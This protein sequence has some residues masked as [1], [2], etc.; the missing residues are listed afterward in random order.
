MLRFK[1]AGSTT[2]NIGTHGDLRRLIAD[3]VERNEAKQPRYGTGRYHHPIAIAAIEGALFNALVVGVDQD[4]NRVVQ[5][6]AAVRLRTLA[7]SA[8]ELADR[9]ES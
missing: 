7:A 1:P 4:V 2:I 6:V 9:L 3:A 5:N 8:V